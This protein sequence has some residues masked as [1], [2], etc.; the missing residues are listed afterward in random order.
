MQLEFPAR[1]DVVA[2]LAFALA[3]FEEPVHRVSGGFEIRATGLRPQDVKGW[4]SVVEDLDGAGLTLMCRGLKA[5][6]K[7]L[8]IENVKTGRKFRLSDGV[9]CPMGDNE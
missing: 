8:S 7:S 1:N 4:A 2:E 6:V 3:V 9:L 5:D